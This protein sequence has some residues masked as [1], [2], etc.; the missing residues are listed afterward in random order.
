M[1]VSASAPTPRVGGAD[2]W[3]SSSHFMTTSSYSSLSGRLPPGVPHG[4]AVPEEDAPSAVA[5]LLKPA[6]EVVPGRGALL[7]P[8]REGGSKFDHLVSGAA[9]ASAIGARWL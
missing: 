4:V 7:V 6:S 3:V 9:Q 8:R 5:G 1:Y 2:G